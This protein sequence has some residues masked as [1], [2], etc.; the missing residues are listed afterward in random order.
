MM[1]VCS[2]GGEQR[3]YGIIRPLGVVCNAMCLWGRVMRQAKIRLSKKVD[4]SLLGSCLHSAC[5]FNPLL[6]NSHS[7]LEYS[8]SSLYGS[9]KEMPHE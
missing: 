7:A 1:T 9:A 2:P 6:P 4:A 3:G 8:Y 5:E